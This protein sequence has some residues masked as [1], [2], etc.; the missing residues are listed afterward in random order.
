MAADG[1]GSRAAR[2]PLARGQTEREG[3]EPICEAWRLLFSLLRSFRGR[4]GAVHAEFEV[5]PVQGHVLQLLEGG[6][7]PMSGLAEGLGCDASNV[8][9][10]VDRLEARGL[11]ERRNAEHDRRVKLL[12]LTVE[13]DRMR[14]ALMD[15]L[16]EPPEAM[17][18]LPLADQKALRDALRRTL[19]AAGITP[20]L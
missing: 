9:G 15:R 7:R 13:G 8:T 19:E 6:P 20:E 14:K 10:L 3:T 17:L 5:T 18:E 11:V 12:A 2:K 1:S 16:M 4:V